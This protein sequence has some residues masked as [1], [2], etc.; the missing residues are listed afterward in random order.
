M[1]IKDREQLEG[2]RERITAVPESVD[3]PAVSIHHR[4]R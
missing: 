3:D 2:G 4:V 1:Q